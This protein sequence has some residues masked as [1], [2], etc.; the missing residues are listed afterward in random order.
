MDSQGIIFDL[1]TVHDAISCVLS[2]REVLPSGTPYPCAL[3][4]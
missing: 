4:P 2:M 3:G 1:E